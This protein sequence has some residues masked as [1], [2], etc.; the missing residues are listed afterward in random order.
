MQES[1]PGIHTT[2]QAQISILGHVGPFQDQSDWEAESSLSRHGE[3][4][5]SDF[6]LG[7]WFWVAF[8]FF[9]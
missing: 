4:M 3:L 5:L 9:V 2:P 8:I 1:I 6:F 7:F